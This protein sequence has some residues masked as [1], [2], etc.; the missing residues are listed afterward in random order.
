MAF[1]IITQEAIKLASGS[2]DSTIRLLHVL[3]PLPALQGMEV[4]SVVLGSDAET[5]VRMSTVPIILV[6]ADPR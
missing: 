2:R 4:I 3:E 6:R 5:V 1:R